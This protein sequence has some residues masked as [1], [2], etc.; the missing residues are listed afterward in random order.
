MAAM[1][2]MTYR[3]L[4]D[5]GLTVSTVGLGCNNFGIKLTAEQ[6]SAVV[7]AA[8]DNGIT[9]FD[10]ADSYGDSEQRLGA[11]LVGRRDDAII[12]TKFGNDV[13]KRGLDNGAD[14]GARGSR[15]Y[16]IRA[17]ESSL[18]RLQTDWIDLL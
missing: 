2:D 8:V 17:V 3:R 1:S 15:R 13:R 11:A 6:S 7:D 14:W 4:G 10:T 16:V 18:R 5:S 12:A 9:L